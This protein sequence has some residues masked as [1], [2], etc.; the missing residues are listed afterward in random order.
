[1]TNCPFDSI[2][3][4]RDIGSL[5][6]FRDETAK[7][8]PAE[9]I[10]GYLGKRSR[11]HGRTPMQWNGEREAGFTSGTPWIK[12]NPNY[13]EIN[14]AEN[15]K[16]EDSVLQFYRRLIALRREH[17]SLV[18]GYYDDLCKESKEVGAYQRTYNGERWVVLCNFTGRSVSLQQLT[19][20]P[21]DGERVLSNYEDRDQNTL[22]PYEALVFR[23]R[24]K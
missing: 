1:M 5:N 15:M 4:Y 12:V 11:D 19:E 10:L 7:G 3:E 8:R 14:V 21:L 2:H 17:R 18:Y 20:I 23:W 9:E 6:L 16:N 24:R 22:R 13:R